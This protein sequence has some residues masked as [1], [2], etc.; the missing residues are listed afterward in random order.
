MKIRI[1]QSASEKPFLALALP[2]PSTHPSTTLASAADRTVTLYDLRS[3]A[4]TNP[5][6][7]TFSHAS[8]PSCLTFSPQE[9][10]QQFVSGAYDGVVRLWDLRSTSREMVSF[11]LW[12]GTK[13]VLGVDWNGS[14]VGI[15]GEGGVEVWKIGQEADK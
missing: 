8:T 12:D 15:A 5:S 11:K 6:T 4:A 3:S 10:S 2:S 7:V 9:G 14:M 1:Q 13:K